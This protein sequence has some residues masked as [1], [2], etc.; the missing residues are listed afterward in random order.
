MVGTVGTGAEWGS[1]GML[2]HLFVG[3]SHFGALTGAEIAGRDGG[4]LGSS[5]ELSPGSSTGASA[6]P[7]GTGRRGRALAFPCSPSHPPLP[8]PG[9][10]TS[11]RPLCLVLAVLLAPRRWGSRH[12]GA[13][14][15]LE[16]ADP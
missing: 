4:V 6:G 2:S 11:P 13:G 7:G 1:A 8:L 5:A 10:L 14:S 9:T 15:G 3:G 16:S 12:C